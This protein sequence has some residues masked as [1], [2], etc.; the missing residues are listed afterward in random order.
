MV[1]V[2]AA[3]K[4]HFFNFGLFSFNSDFLADLGGLLGHIASELATYAGGINQS[5]SLAV[6]NNLGANMQDTKVYRKPWALSGT[7]NAT[8]HPVG[9]AL[10]ILFLLSYCIHNLSLFSAL[11]TLAQNSFINVF[12]ALAFVRLRLLK[13]PDFGCHLPNLL[14]IDTGNGDDILVD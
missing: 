7:N 10:G 9:P 6:V 8:A 11:T 12:N 14:L 2:A 13:S 5:F 4:H 1:A 3:I